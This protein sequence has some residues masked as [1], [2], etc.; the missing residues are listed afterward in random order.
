MFYMHLWRISALLHFRQLLSDLL[1]YLEEL[2]LILHA[3]KYNIFLLK[4]TLII[5]EFTFLSLI[6]VFFNYALPDNIG[7]YIFLYLLFVYYT[8]FQCLILPI[9]YLYI[10]IL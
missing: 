4:S 5:M 10:F 2:Y 1:L 8:F 9:T 3:F 6:L 7:R